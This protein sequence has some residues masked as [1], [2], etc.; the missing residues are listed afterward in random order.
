M[1]LTEAI[2]FIQTNGSGKYKVLFSDGKTK[3]MRLFVSES[4]HVCEFAPRSS[5]RGYPVTTAM[6]V[7][8]SIDKPDYLLNFRRNVKRIIQYLTASGF[9]SSRLQSL[10]FLQQLPDHE[11]LTFRTIPYK[12]W[13]SFRDRHHLS[14][15]F[16]EV[17][18]LYGQDCIKTVRYGTNLGIKEQVKQA[19]AEQRDCDLKW[20]ASYDNSIQLEFKDTEKRAWYSE[21]YC[22]C[23][24]GY[25]YLL[26]D[27]KHVSFLER[28]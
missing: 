5:K 11:L 1:E 12:D 2:N 21:E 28:D 13:S 23:A 6:W 15:S 14:L 8:L 17:Q 26:L 3:E 4:G 25:Y 27:D 10:Q 18:C 19:I 7:G 9:W 24:N 16:D 20:R 22:G